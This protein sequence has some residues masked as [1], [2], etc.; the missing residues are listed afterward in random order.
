LLF[1][2]SYGQDPRMGFEMRKKKNEGTQKI[3]E[4]AKV[5]TRRDKEIY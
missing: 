1:K 3:Q 4:K 2:A 5:V